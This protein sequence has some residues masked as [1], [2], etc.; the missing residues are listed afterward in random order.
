MD[1]IRNTT[2]KHILDWEEEDVHLWFSTLGFSQYE[3]QIKGVV[4]YL[5]ETIH[6][7]LSQYRAQNPRGYSVH[8][9]L[10]SP[11]IV[12][13]SDYWSKAVYPQV[14]ILSQSGE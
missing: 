14:N 7:D 9:G 8:A 11:Q 4:L 5:I 13:N 10:G 2:D 6:L 1:P 3:G 12:W